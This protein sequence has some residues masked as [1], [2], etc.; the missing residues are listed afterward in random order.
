VKTLIGICTKELIVHHKCKSIDVYI[1]FSCEVTLFSDDRKR[2]IVSS[3]FSKARAVRLIV[4]IVIIIIVIMVI[5]VIILI[6]VIIVITVIIVI[7]VI[8]IIVIIVIFCFCDRCL[9]RIVT[10]SK[11]CIFR[12]VCTPYTV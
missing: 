10:S 2:A 3:I 6:I 9:R 4:I 1:N 12:R 5:I 7:I 11:S 8:I